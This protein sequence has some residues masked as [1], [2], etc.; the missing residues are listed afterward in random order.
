MQIYERA[1]IPNDMGA[2]ITIY[3]NAISALEALGVNMAQVHAT[4]VQQVSF[5][6]HETT[7]SH[8]P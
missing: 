5:L 7:Y 2:G 4:R 3:P 6:S 8:S 1:L